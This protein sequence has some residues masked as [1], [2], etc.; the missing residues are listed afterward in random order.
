MEGQ[1][2]VDGVDLVANLTGT[3]NVHQ[4]VGFVITKSMSENSKVDFVITKSIYGNLK[5]IL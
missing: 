1:M 3:E 5:L 2:P 4:K